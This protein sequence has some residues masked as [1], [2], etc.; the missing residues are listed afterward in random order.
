MKQKCLFW[1]VIL[2]DCQNIIYNQSIS[3]DNPKIISQLNSSEN[4]KRITK[5]NF[6]LNDDFAEELKQCRKSISIKKSETGEII[7]QKKY[8]LMEWK[9]QKQMPITLKD[10]KMQFSQRISQTAI[11]E[12][13][14][15]RD[16]SIQFDKESKEAQSKIGQN[17]GGKIEETNSQ[18]FNKLHP[19]SETFIQ[20]YDESLFK[21]N[22]TVKS[23]ITQNQINSD[24]KTKGPKPLNRRPISRSYNA[25]GNN[26]DF[27]E[28]VFQN[29]NKI[30]KIIADSHPVNSHSQNNQLIPITDQEL[31]AFTQTKQIS[32]PIQKRIKSSSIIT[33]SH[34]AN[35]QELNLEIPQTSFKKTLTPI[36]SPLNTISIPIKKKPF[37][38]QIC[39]KSLEELKSKSKATSKRS[40][41]PEIKQ[42]YFDR[43]PDFCSIHRQ[44]GSSLF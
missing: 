20:K 44:T 18:K 7:Y 25:D 27:T 13:N 9:K 3:Q 30:G 14:S 26:I 19:T 12:K 10:S 41:S 21:K 16:Y 43:H 36:K 23:Q 11:M 2:K 35:L 1:K 37:Y 24:K 5:L 32:D 38:H 31:N 33:N 17:S 6:R 8:Y 42:E 39:K 4:I 40:R 15:K 28:T 29:K 22:I 34:L